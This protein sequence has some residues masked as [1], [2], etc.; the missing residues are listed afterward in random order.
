MS[1]RKT[2][3]AALSVLAILVAAVLFTRPLRAKRIPIVTDANTW[4]QEEYRQ[5][6]IAPYGACYGKGIAWSQASAAQNTWYLM[7]DP[8]MDDSELSG[9]THDGSG[10]LTVQYAGIYKIDMAISM[11]NSGVNKHI[12]YGVSVSGADPVM[13]QRELFPA[14]SAETHGSLTRMISLSANDTIQLALRTTDTGTPTI[15]VD[16]LSVAMIGVASP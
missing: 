2:V 11:Q 15:T 8:D 16:N 6:S 1:A 5:F 10:A 9:V 3:A 13:Y 12:E 14:T 7:S 4:S